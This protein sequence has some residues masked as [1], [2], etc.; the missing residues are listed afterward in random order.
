MKIIYVNTR[1]LV[2]PV[3]YVLKQ[4]GLDIVQRLSYEVSAEI[5]RLSQQK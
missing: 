3:L 4:A 1:I 5:L 2:Y